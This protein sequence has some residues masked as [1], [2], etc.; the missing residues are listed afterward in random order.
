[1]AAHKL[2]NDILDTIRDKCKKK[3]ASHE[4]KSGK[5]ENSFKPGLLKFEVQGS[6]VIVDLTDDGFVC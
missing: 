4:Q 1:M 6:I 3:K 5:A 2:H